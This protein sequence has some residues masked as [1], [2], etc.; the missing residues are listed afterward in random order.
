LLS[1]SLGGG[2]SGILVGKSFLCRLVL[3]LGCSLYRLLFLV[4]LSLGSGNSEILVCK[5]FLRGLVLLPGCLFLLLHLSLG[6]GNSGILVS[7]DFLRGKVLILG[8]LPKSFGLLHCL[9]SCSLQ[10]FSLFS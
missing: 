2:N 8:C 6:G 10:L 7:D 9:L 4:S 5:S 3:L 1:L